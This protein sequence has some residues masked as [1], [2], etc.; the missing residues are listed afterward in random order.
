MTDTP[1]WASPSSSEPPRDD[2]RPPADASAAVPGQ[3]APPQGAPVPP[4]GWGGP[5]VPPAQPGWGGPQGPYGPYG[6][7]PYGWGPPPSPKPGIIPLRPLGLG[8]LLDGSVATI[9]KHWRTALSLSLG[10]A[11][12]QQAGG[13]GAELL[14]GGKTGDFTSVL[15]SLVSLPVDLLLGVIAT[16]LLTVVVSRAILGQSVT[17]REAWRDARPR[18]LQLLGLTLLTAL[19]VGGVTLLG[20]APLIGYAVAGAAQPAIIGLLVIVGLLSLP[21]AVWLWIRLSLAAPALMLE[22]QGVMTALSRSRRLVRG[23]WWRIFGITL[24][25]QLIAFVVSCV[26]AIPFTTVGLVLGLGDLQR[27]VASGGA[28]LP[29]AMLIT[30]AIAGVIS[31][32]LTIPFTAGIGVLL[33]VDQR[34]RREALDIE[35]ARAAGLPEYGGTGWSGQS[36]P[37]PTKL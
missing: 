20:F 28:G 30:T 11:V 32:T 18:M 15:V 7:P 34:I 5:H 33:Y 25:S 29:M 24:L 35:L 13:I 26:I 3:S 17:I 37:N 6:Q 1:G 4:P 9:R 19:I 36:G 21:A 16:A 23:E 10:I 22:K 31:A 2:T 14:V 27:Q 12:L 8:E